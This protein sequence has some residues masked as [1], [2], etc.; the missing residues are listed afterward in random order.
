MNEDDLSW[1]QA[2]LIKNKLIALGISHQNIV[3]AGYGNK[4]KLLGWEDKNRI[5]IGFM[6]IGGE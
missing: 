4:N 2:T 3:T 5:E 6:L 1:H